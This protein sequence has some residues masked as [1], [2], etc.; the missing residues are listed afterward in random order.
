MVFKYIDI[1]GE[2]TKGFDDAV[3]NAIAETAQTV[4]DI[5]WADVTN[6]KVIV[7]GDKITEY[8]ALMRV[9]FKV[10]R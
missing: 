10:K 7:T 9:A 1:L 5:R 4:K 3:Q 8:Q 2:S 6:L